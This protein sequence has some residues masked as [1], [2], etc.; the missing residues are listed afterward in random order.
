MIALILAPF[1]VFGVMAIAFL[2][3]LGRNLDAAGVR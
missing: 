1:A 3:R 2:C